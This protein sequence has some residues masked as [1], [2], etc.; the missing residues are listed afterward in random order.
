INNAVDPA[1]R[2]TVDGLSMMLGSLAS[3]VGPTV[4]STIFAW[5][6]ERHRPFPLDNHLIFC[7]FALG[8]IV[9][10]AM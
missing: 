3:A 8:M 4:C 6:I 2:G 5:S 1:Q 7:L 10:T 9:I